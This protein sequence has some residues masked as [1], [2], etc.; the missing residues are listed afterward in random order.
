M[1]KI[2]KLL[3]HNMDHMLAA[4]RLFR[5][6]VP[7]EEV[8]QIYLLGF[9]NPKIFRD[10][11]SNEHNCNY[12]HGFVKRYGNV[13]ALDKD[14]N[15]LTLWDGIPEE[16]E[17]R[18]SFAECAALVKNSPINSIF[19]ETM[20]FLTNPAKCFY[21]NPTPKST[22]TTIRLG[23]DQN[24]KQYNKQEAEMYPAAG[25]KEG[26][27]I[28]FHHMHVTVPISIIDR[29]G[30]DISAVA[31]EVNDVVNVFERGLKEISTDTMELILDLESEGAILNGNMFR[32]AVEKALKAAREYKEIPAD[33]KHNWCW[34]TAA[35]LGQAAKFRNT[36]IG[37]LM[38]EL[39]EGREINEAVMAFNR[40]VDP[41]NYKKASAPI[42]KKQIAEAQKFVEENGYEES[43]NR[44][45][46]TIDDINASE[47]LHENADAAQTKTKVSVFDGMKSTAPKSRHSRNEFKNVEEVSYEKFMSDI[48]PHVTSMEV[49]LA[50]NLADDFVTLLTS[51][52]KDSKRMFAW[53]NN[54]SWTYANGLTGVSQIKTAVKEAGGFVDAPF[55]FSILW[56]D[57]DTPG[58][59][60]FDAHAYEGPSHQE[61]YYGSYRKPSHTQLGGELDVDMINPRSKGVENIYWKDWSRLRDGEY[62]FW[63]HNFNGR[64]NQGFKAELYIQGDTYQYH[65]P[66]QV[67]QDVEIARVTIKGGQVVDIKHN[68][69]YMTDGFGVSRE[70]FGLQ[71]NEFHKVTLCCYSPNYWGEK[72]I[73][74]KHVF[75]MLKDAMAPTDI[76]TFHNEFLCDDLYDHRKVMEVLGSRLKAKST[77]GQLS[78]L[79]FNTTVHGKE[80]IVKLEGSHK[81]MLKIKF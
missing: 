75:F 26:Q 14:L 79:G 71:T 4:G 27:I 60:D 22:T 32:P 66:H 67:K 9:E 48:L 42:S 20:E 54:F 62:R 15:V 17:Y 25:I 50:N 69:K 2:N 51:E 8:W 44:R 55:R 12:C 57:E 21:N 5:T 19:V 16:E 78:G 41:V 81:R 34:V 64:D 7:G 28:T 65:V 77:K 40:M 45:C 73:G 29:S 58:I 35:K 80:L 68:E 23:L 61:I 46:A 36:A 76:R 37:T 13:V 74:A 18:R 30:R 33:K 43:L 11:T 47:I 38:I 56:N 63:V 1:E 6:S 70:V 53:D 3:Q 59:V 72:G 39:A 52:N 49:F 24:V 31:A 10:P